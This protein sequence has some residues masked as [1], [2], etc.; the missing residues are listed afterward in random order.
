MLSASADGIGSAAVNLIIGA[1]PAPEVAVYFLAQQPFA[2]GVF[3]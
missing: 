1:P 2:A 3:A